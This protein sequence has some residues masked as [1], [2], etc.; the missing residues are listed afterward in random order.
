[1]VTVPQFDFGGGCGKLDF[2]F[3][4]FFFFF[5]GLGEGFSTSAVAIYCVYVCCV[6]PYFLIV[7]TKGNVL[8]DYSRDNA[9]K[10]T[11][12]NQEDIKFYDLEILLSGS[13][14]IV[15]YDKDVVSSDDIMCW[16]W[17][18]AS[19]CATEKY[20][21]LTKEEVDG[22]GVH[23]NIWNDKK[24]RKFDDRFALEFLFDT[25]V[26]EEKE[27]SHYEK[28]SNPDIWREI[29]ASMGKNPSMLF[30]AA[31]NKQ[32]IDELRQRK[33]KNGI[34]ASLPPH[35]PLPE[36]ADIRYEKETVSSYPDLPM[37]TKEEMIPVNEQNRKILENVINNV[38]SFLK[39]YTCILL[40]K[41]Y[42]FTWS[43]DE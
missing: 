5:F 30:S 33:S 26:D 28:Q 17:L 10:S 15:F 1:M 41:D 4:S 6:D 7:D 22:A 37:A 23:K 16:C 35:K 42:S 25:P 11:S 3:L 12:L 36:R 9:V 2:F 18:H 20:I 14:K 27:K 19:V 13:F 24:S 32:K 21:R 31:V 43:I 40:E 29:S 38:L 8:Y 34:I 39:A